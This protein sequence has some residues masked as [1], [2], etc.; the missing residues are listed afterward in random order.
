MVSAFA[1]FLFPWFWAVFGKA[2]HVQVLER[3]EYTKKGEDLFP[4][5]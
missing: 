3:L 1:R 4:D 2:G 5:P